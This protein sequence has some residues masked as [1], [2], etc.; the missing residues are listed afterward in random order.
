MK[1]LGMNPLEFEDLPYYWRQRALLAMS[2][3]NSVEK[4]LMDRASRG[5]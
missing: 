3:E 1:D 5:T 4:E 2:T